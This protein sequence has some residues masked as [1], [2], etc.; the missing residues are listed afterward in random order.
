MEQVRSFVAIELPDR[1]KDELRGLE[2]QL[3]SA[4]N[5]AVKWVDPQSIHL[6][7]KFL[8]NVP[9][10]TLAEII[11]AMEGVMAG[12]PP[13][14]LEV[15]ELGVFPNLR[16]LQIIWV[17]LTGDLEPLRQLQKKVESALAPLGFPPEAREFTPHLTLARVREGMPPDERE[18]LGKLVIST[19]FAVATSI[20]VDAISLMRS[21][22][23]RAG[24]IYSRIA[25][26]KLAGG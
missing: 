3:K 5:R 17:G 25:L 26:I 22:L 6:T 16:R 23:T 21:Q 2:E 15:K 19:R 24:A 1:L 8:G 7:L 4:G 10:G 13:F 9:T 18:R 14:H 11:K 12:I 20:D